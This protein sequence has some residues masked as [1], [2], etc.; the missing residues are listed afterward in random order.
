MTAGTAEPPG[1]LQ[2]FVAPLLGVALV[3]A[4]AWAGW[5][6]YRRLPED[7]FGALGDRRRGELTALRIVLRRPP[8]HTPAGEEKIPVQ[9]Y[10]INVEA[11]RAEYVS[12]RRPGVRFEEFLTRRMSG[13]EPPVTSEFDERG[14]A[15]VAVPQGRWWIHATLDGPE[16]LSWRL[17]VNVSGREKTVEL[18]TDNIYTR[19]KSF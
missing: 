18:T 8:G 14:E 12:E 5:G 3:V 16:E 6:I 1:P 19:A 11:A 17:P 9:L 15:A 7:S 2:Q 10:S 4:L 13:R